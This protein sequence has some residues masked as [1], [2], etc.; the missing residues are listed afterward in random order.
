MAI[1]NRTALF[2]ALFDA[3]R[4]HPDFVYFAGGGNPYRFFFKDRFVTVFIGNVHFANRAE[5]D[6]YRIQCPGDLPERLRNSR[7]RGDIILILGFSAD[8]HTFSAWAPDRFLARD[9][10]V[11][12]FSLYTRLPRMQEAVER[13]LSAHIDTDGQI[14]IMFRPDFIGLYAENPTVLHQATTR[15]LQR[16]A[17]S[18]KQSPARP[19]VMNRQKIR[20]TNIE[21]LRSPTF[22]QEVLGAYAHRCA[23]CGIQLDLV[24]AAHIVPHAHPQGHDVISNGL[25]LC[26]LH[27]RSFDTGLLYVRDDYS[28]HLNLTRVR[29][30]KKVGRADGLRRYRREL[31]DALVLPDNDDWLPAPDNL[32]LGNELRGVELD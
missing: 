19:I 5:S 8:V 17:Q 21:Y 22:R 27:H 24:D 30:L 4:Q 10:R 26:T 15:T 32:V 25:A 23:M 13:G 20:V 18:Y 29:H 16:V 7:L 14:V 9:S 31:R 6:E 3:F 28:I 2:H 1:L 12:R 11:R